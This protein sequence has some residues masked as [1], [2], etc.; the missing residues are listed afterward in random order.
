VL[1]EDFTRSQ[2]ELYA[3]WRS[4]ELASPLRRLWIRLRRNRPAGTPAAVERLPV[5]EHE[6]DARVTL[7]AA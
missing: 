6:P 5:P 7:P 2:S 3:A 4:E 1:S